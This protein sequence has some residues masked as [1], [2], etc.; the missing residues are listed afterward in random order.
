VAPA[1]EGR[2]RTDGKDKQRLRWDASFAR[3]DNA[4]KYDY[5]GDDGSLPGLWPVAAIPS[6][7]EPWG[8]LRLMAV[9]RLLIVWHRPSP[10]MER[11]IDWFHWIA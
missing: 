4:E 7:R 1:N 11:E 9:L 8:P 2:N 5:D 10:S 3:C 6:L